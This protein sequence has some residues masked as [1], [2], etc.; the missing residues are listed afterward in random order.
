MESSPNEKPFVSIIVPVYNVE[1]YINE[2]I[3][4]I[5][6]QTYTRYE[7]ILI[8]DHSQDKSGEICDMYASANS[9]VYTI[10]NDSRLGVS[11]ARNIGLDL[12]QGEWITFIDSDDFISESYL[13]GLVSPILIDKGIDFIHAGCVNWAHGKVSS[14]NQQYDNHIDDNPFLLFQ[15]FRGL[16]PSKLFSKRII[17]EHSLRFDMKMSIAEDMAFTLEYIVFVSRY[18]FTNEIGYYYRRDNATSST[19]T[20]ILSYEDSLYCFNKLYSCTLAFIESKGLS[21]KQS[22]Y[23]L[24]QRAHNL[25]STIWRLYRGNYSYKERICHMKNDF[26]TSQLNILKYMSGSI[27]Y[28]IIGYALSMRCY[29]F[30]DVVLSVSVKFV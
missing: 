24:S 5:L 30:V 18:A 19:K 26:T 6:N 16:V 8:D 21:V 15:E 13:D 10:H 1:N 28:R 12:A 23:R 9:N 25:V 3:S 2:C 17:E 4:S 29:R 27:K 7:L 22:K 11:Y 14:I 20:T